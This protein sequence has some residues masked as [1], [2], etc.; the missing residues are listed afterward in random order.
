LTCV[1]IDENPD[2]SQ[3][4]FEPIPGKKLFCSSHRGLD[5]ETV[6]EHRTVM[7]SPPAGIGQRFGQWLGL[8]DDQTLDRLAYRRYLSQKTGPSW[9]GSLR[10]WMIFIQNQSC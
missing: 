9:P 2:Q 1:L 5:E 6:H 3:G 8:A 10:F 7:Q 4:G